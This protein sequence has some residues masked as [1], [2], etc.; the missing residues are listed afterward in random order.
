MKQNLLLALDAKRARFP[1][2]VLA[3]IRTSF[4]TPAA[5][6]SSG[7]RRFWSTAF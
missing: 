5:R 3:S 7:S 6:S 4:S 2:P 1:D